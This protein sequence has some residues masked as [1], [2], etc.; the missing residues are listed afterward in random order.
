MPDTGDGEKK[1]DLGLLEAAL[2]L[3]P[4][5]LSRRRLAKIL[6]GASLAYIDRLLEELREELSNPNHGIELHVEDG[7]ALLQVKRPYIDA[8]AHLAPQ[9]DIPRP[10]LRS[11]AMIAYNHPMTQADLVRARG[12]K[13]YGHVQELIERRLIRAEEQGRTL[14]LHVTDE[15][16][17]HFGLT[18]VEEFRF[19]VQVPESEEENPE[20]ERAEPAEGAPIEEGSPCNGE[21]TEMNNTSD[22]ID[23]KEVG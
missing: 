19:H 11:L 5:P 21:S 15:F 2:F 3:T 16:L 14:L 23:R 12:N 22:I 10:V 1:S 9:Q 7:K 17:R 4:K 20:E 6:D 13:A 18:S 8:V